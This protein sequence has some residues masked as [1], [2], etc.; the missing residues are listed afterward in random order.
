M[1]PNKQIRL[2][3]SDVK[4]ERPSVQTA[5]ATKEQKRPVRNGHR[6]RQER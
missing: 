5:Q 4:L 1:G 3:G 2:S 6:E